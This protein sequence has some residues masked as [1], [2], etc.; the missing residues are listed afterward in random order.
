MNLLSCIVAFA[1]AIEICLAGQQSLTP[2]IE[3]SEVQCFYVEV[4]NTNYTFLQLYYQVL[5]G[6]DY[7]IRLYVI[8]PNENF[9]IEDER[10]TENSHRIPLHGLGTYKCCFDNSFSYQTAKMVYILFNMFVSDSEEVSEEITTLDVHNIIEGMDMTVGNMKDRLGKM[11]KRLMTAENLMRSGRIHEKQD[12]A[13]LDSKLRHVNFWS[14]FNSAA[15]IV[16]GALQIF[17]IKSLFE[18]RSRIG[19]FLRR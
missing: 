11:R 19:K 18:E 7:D 1:C 17:L 10:T 14:M 3:A 8:D 9:I 16:I 5:S 15:I 12:R 4:T 13:F 2:I 6:G